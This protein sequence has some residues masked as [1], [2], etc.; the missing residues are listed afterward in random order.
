MENMEVT[1]NAEEWEQAQAVVQEVW[2]QV[3]VLMRVVA[4]ESSPITVGV[5]EVNEE[6]ASLMNAGWLIHTAQFLT[7]DP[8]NF[9][10]CMLLVRN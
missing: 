2:T 4:A 1:E 10:L 9:R 5:V 3:K 7:N 8:G 6:L